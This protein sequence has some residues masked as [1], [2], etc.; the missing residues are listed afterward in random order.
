MKDN[1][2]KNRSA[3][4]SRS[5]VEISHD[6][7]GRVDGVTLRSWELW[8]NLAVCFCVF[9][10]VGHWMEIPYCLFN[11]YVFGIVDPETLVYDDPM[12]PFLVYGIGA[13]LCTLVF[14]P[15]KEWLVR[16]CATL[17]NALTIF[18]MASVLMCMVME[19]GMGLL[20][21]QPDA[22]GVYPLWDNS[23]LPFNIL[24]QAWLVND[25]L[26][27]V[28][29]SVYSWIVWPLLSFLFR[30]IPPLAMNVGS[31]LLVIAFV[32]LCVVKFS[33]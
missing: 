24:D 10:V 17:L 28:V 5:R 16:R 14:V 3:E 12:Y 15:L 19:L 30:K 25:I 22:S 1:S 21:N 27:G 32:I 8:R 33:V 11:D 9:S 29:A 6:A 18:F 4:S 13:C 20:L 7:V 26:L 31:V 23:E 2:K